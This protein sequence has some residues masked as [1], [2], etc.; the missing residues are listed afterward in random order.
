MCV[1]EFEWREEKMRAPLG[2]V[3]RLERTQE[4]C[5]YGWPLPSL[6]NSRSLSSEACLSKHNIHIHF[7]LKASSASWKR[8]LCPGLS[9]E[10]HIRLAS[11][12]V[13]NPCHW[14]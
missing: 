9:S 6:G 4:C 11:I 8:L 12:D 5:S 13:T 3:E 10:P 7:H 1:L 14:G 2:H